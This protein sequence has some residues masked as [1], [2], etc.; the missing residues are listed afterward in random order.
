MA[1]LAEPLEVL[2]HVATSLGL[3]RLVV[4]RDAGA[5]FASVARLVHELEMQLG[6]ERLVLDPLRRSRV[7]GHGTIL[8]EA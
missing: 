1:G 8:S 2:A 7:R 3:E 4:E 6:Q 5:L